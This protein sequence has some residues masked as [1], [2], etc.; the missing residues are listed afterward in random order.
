MTPALELF[1]CTLGGTEGDADTLLVAFVHDA[2][3][4]VVPNKVQSRLLTRYKVD[5]QLGGS[6]V[7][8]PSLRK[9]T[10]AAVALH[11]SAVVAR[12]RQGAE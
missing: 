10:G 6:T 7:R 11:V 1:G 3:P 8:R 2:V 9:A 4:E 12:W 5:K